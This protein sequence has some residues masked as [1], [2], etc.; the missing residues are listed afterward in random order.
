MRDVKIYDNFNTET[1]NQFNFSVK[2]Y[3]R[4][5]LTPMSSFFFR[6]LLIFALRGKL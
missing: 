5:F 6:H 3:D 1:S 2:F 4:G